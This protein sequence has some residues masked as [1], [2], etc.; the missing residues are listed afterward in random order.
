MLVYYSY[1]NRGTEENVLLMLVYCSYPNR[2][3][4]ENVLLM[5]VYCILSVSLRLYKLSVL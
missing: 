2:G 5:L 4:E 3:T 1:L